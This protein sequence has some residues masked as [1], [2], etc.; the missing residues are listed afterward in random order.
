MQG[1]PLK[2]PLADSALVVLLLLLG[3][4]ALIPGAMLML[5]P[6]GHLIQMPM[7]N[8]QQAPFRDYFI[9]GLLLFL[10]VGV[11]P[12]AVAYGLWRTPG[13]QWPD[14]I[15]P[16]KQ[17]HWSWAGSLAAG[18]IL[19]VWI[20][21]QVFLIKSIDFLHYLYWGWGAVLIVL[22]LIPGVR[23]FHQL[24]GRHAPRLEG[25]QGRN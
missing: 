22:T 20:T 21:V 9:P 3:V 23:R 8:L 17:Q 5:A 24:D 14:L 2:R 10:F 19:I 25:R 4:S 15:N 18:V 7:S 12:V 13:W 11:F 16:F 1:S 6:D